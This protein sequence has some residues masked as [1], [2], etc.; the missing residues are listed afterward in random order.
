MNTGTIK[1]IPTSGLANRLRVIAFSIRLARESNKQLIIYWHADKYL[2]SEFSD[3][4]EMP[5]NITVNKLPL[6][7]KVWLR[8][9]KLSAR[10]NRIRNWYLRQ[11]K[12]DFI[13]LDRMANEVWKNRLN[14]QKEVDKARNVLICSCQEIN[15]F[16][17]SDYQQFIPVPNIQNK[18]NDQ[19]IQFKPDIIGIHI[20]TT[21]NAESI[22]NSPFH[23]FVKKIEEELRM[24]EDA[25]FFLATD[26]EGYQN[27]LIEKFG[28][29]KILFY[30]KEFRREL[31]QGIKDAVVDLF[32]LAKTSKIYGSYFSSFSDVAGRIGQI[33]VVVMK[34]N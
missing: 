28:T 3:L 2:N 5:G 30:K 31:N 12:F 10:L 14:L 25:T 21:D 34:G 17:L 13:F 16:N 26:N 6:S 7:Y 23:L 9:G 32:C 11:F 24:N 1:V 29:D 15:H 8:S 20:R 4:F 19:V 18:I 27:Q 22:K 33:P